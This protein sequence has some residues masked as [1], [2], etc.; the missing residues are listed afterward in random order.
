[1]WSS[2]SKCGDN[3]LRI[4]FSSIRNTVD[5]ERRWTRWR[6]SL[7]APTNYAKNAVMGVSL[8]N[9]PGTPKTIYIDAH[10]MG[11]ASTQRSLSRIDGSVPTN[12]ESLSRRAL[13]TS[14]KRLLLR[15]RAS[16]MWNTW[17]DVTEAR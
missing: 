13:G 10:Y 2:R 5:A 9:L 1:M 17:R 15:R 14:G 4:K 16:R 6:L 7:G 11:T 12:L 8:N 3:P